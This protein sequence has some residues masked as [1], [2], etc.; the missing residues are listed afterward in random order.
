MYNT[1]ISIVVPVYNLDLF[2]G[3]CIESIR[4]QSFTDFELIL[5]DDGS[6]DNSLEIC[7]NYVNQDSRI[8]IIENTHEGVSAARNLGIEKATGEYIAFIDGDD[9]IHPN[10]LE[11]LYTTIKSCDADIVITGFMNVKSDYVI[12]N[13][14]DTKTF[15]INEITQDEIY[16]CLLGNL[17]YINIWG[18]LYK[19]SII[20]NHRFNNFSLGEDV[21]FNSRVYNICHKIVMINIP[22]YY[23]NIRRGSLSHS[24]FSDNDIS[25]LKAFHF[26]YN[27]VQNQDPLIK[28]IAL[29]RLYKDLLSIRYRVTPQYKKEVQ[30]CF[31]DIYFSTINDFKKNPKISPF[32]KI[33]M[34]IFFK[35]PFSYRI[36]RS[37]A[38][39]ISSF[40]KR[41]E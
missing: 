19:K 40:I 4:N 10:Y 6:S 29:I 11:Y 5:V 37:C 21:E 7:K 28:K 32:V 34:L 35:M 41:K 26:I 24:K 13:H 15:Q 12:D 30:V 36:F 25:C 22:L 20:G 2:I 16:S 27:N 38:S 31:E 17:N 23:Y 3:N 1:K 9:L 8:F 39:F 14:L 18:R 33:V